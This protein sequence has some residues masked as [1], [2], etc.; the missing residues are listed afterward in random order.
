MAKAKGASGFERDIG[1]LLP[2]LDRVEGAAKALP[3]PASRER[4]GR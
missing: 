2:F 4:Q 1:Y 3:D